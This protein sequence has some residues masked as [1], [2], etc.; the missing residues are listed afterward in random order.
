MLII[1]LASSNLVSAQENCRYEFKNSSK[2]I[3][4]RYLFNNEVLVTGELQCKNEEIDTPYGIEII[5]IPTINNEGELMEEDIV[6]FRSYV[7][8]YGDR[9]VVW[10]RVLIPMCCGVK[11][12]S[13]CE[14]NST[15]FIIKTSLPFPSIVVAKKP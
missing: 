2:E 6:V 9:V 13:I 15:D 14:E 3:S 5:T 4:G 1:F 10:T 7:S 12:E 8:L 11:I